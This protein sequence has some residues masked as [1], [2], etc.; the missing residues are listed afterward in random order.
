MKKEQIT[1][2]AIIIIAAILGGC[3]DK[4]QLK[5]EHPNIVYLLA[6]DMGMGDLG[7]YNPESKIP[8]PAMDALARE[9]MMFT[10]AHSGSA[11][12]TPTR[13]GILTGTYAFRTR[14]KSGVLWGSSQTLIKG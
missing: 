11:V 5:A 13:Y 12:C 3:Q 4:T 8:T 9:G 14:L 2:I 7:C 6:D 1:F 10:D